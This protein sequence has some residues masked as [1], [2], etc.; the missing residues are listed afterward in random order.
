MHGKTSKPA[1][2]NRPDPFWHRVY[3]AVVCVTFVVI[4]ALWGFSKYFSN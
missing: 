2:P 4:T 3:L 1:A